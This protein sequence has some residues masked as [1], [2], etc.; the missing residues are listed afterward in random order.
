M[1]MMTYA[2]FKLVTVTY[3]EVHDAAYNQYTM[4]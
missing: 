4:V 3:H 1:I 2:A